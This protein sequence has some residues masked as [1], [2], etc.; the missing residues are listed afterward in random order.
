MGCL[1]VCLHWR[2][3]IVYAPCHS[4]VLGSRFFTWL[5]SERDQ[6]PDFVPG[7]AP[8]AS[9]ASGTAFVAS[10]VCP[11]MAC[12]S[13][14]SSSAYLRGSSKRSS[15]FQ[16]ASSH[17]CSHPLGLFRAVAAASA[18]AAFMLA[19]RSTSAMNSRGAQGTSPQTPKPMP[20]HPRLINEIYPLR[21]G[22]AL[23]SEGVDMRG[24]V[25]FSFFVHVVRPN[26]TTEHKRTRT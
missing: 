22:T 23:I 7:P 11:W 8:L 15:S 14:K 20:T 26:Q 9:G 18:R 19:T 17:R 3:C 4:M 6:R 12:D 24:A 1:L 10:W 13:Q 25:A 21:S 5:G 16:M 2:L